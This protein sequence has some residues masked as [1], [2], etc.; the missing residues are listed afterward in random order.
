MILYQIK[1][2]SIK[3]GFFLL[4]F[5]F[6]IS[7]E[8]QAQQTPE[9]ITGKV[10]YVSSRN[11]YV[12]FKSTRLLNSGDTL[13]RMVNGQLT[14][15]LIIQN[16]SSTSC[17]CT[18]L[19]SLTFKRD[20]LIYTNIK[21]S[22]TEIPE[23]LTSPVENP[24]QFPIDS[25]SE[26]PVNPEST[27]TTQSKNSV[28]KTKHWKGRLSLASYSTL[29]SKFSDDSHRFQYTFNA[30]GKNLAGL[31]LTLESYISFRHKDGEWYKVRED[32]NQ[33]LKIY[34]LSVGYDF[35]DDFKISVGRK[36]NYKISSLGVIDGLQA[37]YKTGVFELGGIYGSRPDY[38]NYGFNFN[39]R[40]YGLY[41]NHHYRNNRA[42]DIQQTISWVEQLNHGKTDRRFLYLQHTGTFWSK[43]NLFGSSEID[44]FEN[45]RDTA[46]RIFKLSN[47][48]LS[49]R[50]RVSR[51]FSLTVSYD[52]RSNVIY[53]ETYK[54]EIDRLLDEETRQGL[55]FQLQMNPIKRLS[56]S[57]G[58]NF[59]FQR[60]GLNES[61]NYNI[62]VSYSR[63]PIFNGPLSFSYNFLKTS[64]VTSKVAGI[65]GSKDFMDGKLYSDFY[66]RNIHYQNINF[67]YNSRQW[68]VGLSAN[69]RL[70]K[71]HSMGVY[72]EQTFDE[73]DQYL[74]MNIRG[75]VRF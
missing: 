63:I 14:P 22:E 36:S 30:Q 20:D 48:Y 31:P 45:I 42:I 6:G 46:S 12:K 15:V 53:Y 41:L 26:F 25:L 40:E 56:V 33:A 49:L 28:K 8:L 54:N 32:L 67:D 1:K 72:L 29:G 27:V 74:R 55:R 73:N 34:N 11:V 57:V 7:L 9:Y 71:L 19:D 59:R 24:D 66:I 61:F 51:K 37:S 70:T 43:V 58:S 52:A 10:S 3:F 65:Q 13:F 39:F 60:N 50:Y 64:F 4:C 21:T 18:T 2:S 75:M 5:C 17:V 38:K 62:Y 23:D 16:K 47:L 69:V 44:L 35:S 68:L